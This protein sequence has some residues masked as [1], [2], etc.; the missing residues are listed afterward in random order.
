ME[1]HSNAFRDYH[2]QTWLL[3][4]VPNRLGLVAEINQNQRQ[5]VEQPMRVWGDDDKVPTHLVLRYQK[6]EVRNRKDALSIKSDGVFI[7][8][9]G[10]INHRS[11]GPC[12]RRS[13]SALKSQWVQ[14]SIR[15]SSSDPEIYPPKFNWWYRSPQ[16]H[17]RWMW[18]LSTSDAESQSRNKRTWLE[19]GRTQ[20]ETAALPLMHVAGSFQYWLCTASLLF[21][22]FRCKRGKV[23]SSPHLTYSNYKP[24]GWLPPRDRGTMGRS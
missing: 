13:R 21:G 1:T 16:L 4:V 2:Y 17:V 3:W 23:I 8:P 7:Q 19:L 10:N 22:F 9:T 18:G 12:R 14:V 5:L 20:V 6:A 11:H 24:S 15:N